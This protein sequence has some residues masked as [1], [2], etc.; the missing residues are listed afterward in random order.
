MKGLG[1]YADFHNADA[2]GRLRL[3]CVGTVQDL[4][5]G[6]RLAHT[7]N[8]GNLRQ[9]ITLQEGLR[10]NLY[11]EELEVEGEVLY[12]GEENVW[13]AAIDWAAI[14]EVPEAAPTLSKSA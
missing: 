2:L 11:S 4:A 3:N 12:S 8:A 5:E 9:H 1:V 10:L 6:V 13:V 7:G 14:Q